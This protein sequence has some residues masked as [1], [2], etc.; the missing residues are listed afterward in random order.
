[1][2]NKIVI[3]IKTNLLDID[4][5]LAKEMDT[6]QRNGYFV[7]LL[8]WDRDLKNDY[9]KRTDYDEIILKLKAP[10]GN[11]IIFF[12]PIWWCFV[13]FQLLTV[14][15]D[16]VHAIN[17]DCII[18]AT[19]AAKIKRKPIIYEMFD[20]YEDMIKLPNLIRNTGII[21]D[22]W[23]MKMANGIIIVDES[24]VK[25]FNGI[26]NANI[27]IVYNVPLDVNYQLKEHCANGNKFRIFYAGL[28]GEGR[29]IE[30]VITAVQDLENVEFIIAGFGP[31]LPEIK[32]KIASS[33]GKIKYI[34]SIKHS[35]VI[36]NTFASD[37][38][39][40]LYDPIIRLNKFASS[41]KLFESMMCNKPILVSRGSSMDNIVIKENCGLVVDCNDIEKIKEVIIKLKENPE[42]CFQLGANGRKAH[43]LKY[44][45]KIMEQRLLDLYELLFKTKAKNA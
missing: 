28:L 42:L 43:D 30:N 17:L 5:R 14:Q 25:E 7:K 19:F 3:F 9:Q 20:T 29:S 45:W 44:N 38:L 27:A 18:P 34:G 22:K 10:W 15:W 37:L 11:S 36:E 2:D 41:N 39:F 35:E 26:P 8:C 40:S 31:Q 1:M 12:L 6:L 24:R 23:F 32:R 16:M 13:F 21:I 4:P 33:K